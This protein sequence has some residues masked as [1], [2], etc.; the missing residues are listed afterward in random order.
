M[1]DKK[2]TRAQCSRCLSVG[3]YNLTESAAIT[4]KSCDETDYAYT[5]DEMIAQGWSGSL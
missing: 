1:K 4:C 3:W 5:D 2:L